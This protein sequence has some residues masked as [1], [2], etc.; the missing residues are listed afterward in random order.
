MLQLLCAFWIIYSSKNIHDHHHWVISST[1]IL[2]RTRPKISLQSIHTPLGDKVSMLIHRYPHNPGGRFKS[3]LHCTITRLTAH[4]VCGLMSDL[5]ICTCLQKVW[6][7]MTP[8]WVPGVMSTTQTRPPNPFITFW[9]MSTNKQTNQRHQ[10]HNLLCQGGKNS[11]SVG[12]K[13]LRLDDL[14]LKWRLLIF[15]S[16]IK[17]FSVSLHMSFQVNWFSGK[18]ELMPIKCAN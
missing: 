18:C 13:L 2:P 6:S 15:F 3:R 10:K 9:V 8:F 11:K 17:S 1:T 4:F 7:Y 5:L 16:S 14:N 12:V